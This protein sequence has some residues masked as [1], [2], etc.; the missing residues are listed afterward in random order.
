MK[1][2]FTFLAVAVFAVGVFAQSPEKISY[3]AVIRNT[4]DQLVAEQ[5][6]GVQ[7][8]I[9]KGATNGTPVYVETHSATTNVNGLVTIEIGTGTTSD[10]FSFIEWGKGTYLIKTETDPTTAGGTN[11]TI[12]GVSQLLS[13]PYALHSKSAETITGEIDYTETDPVYIASEAGNITATDISNLG[14]LSGTN[15]GDQDLS[16]YATKD[17]GNENISNLADPAN[18]QDAAT[19]AYVDKLKAQIEE[20]YILMGI[21]VKDIDGNKYG[22]VTIGTQVWMTENLKTTKFNDGT[23]IVNLTDNAEWA[24]S[25]TPAYCWYDNDEVSYKNTNGAL[26]NWNTIDPAINGNKNVCPSGWHVPT[27]AEWLILINYLIDN[28][29]GVGGSGDDI[30]KSL[31]SQSGWTTNPT[32][33][34]VGNDPTSNNSS[35]FN[36]VPSGARIYLEGTFGGLGEVTTW[37]TSTPIQYQ[38]KCEVY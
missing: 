20:L 17:M 27:D 7:V 31:A 33:G 30:A 35:G 9:L 32:T 11:Y 3:Q 18:D 16:A 5:S 6:I 25:T 22:V 36:A 24:A 34:N 19:K 10:D 4:S 12:T 15:T 13:V 2:I 14:N 29:Y 28:G 38:C 21:V 23:P 37:W 8:S 1:R 26:Y